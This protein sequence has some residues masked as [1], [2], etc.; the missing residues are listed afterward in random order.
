MAKVLK[1][2]AVVL[3][4]LLVAVCVALCAYNIY[5]LVSCYAFGN[6]MPTVFGYAGAAVGSGSMDD[7]SGGDDI[8]EGDFVIVKSQQDYAVGDVITFYWDG[9]YVTHRVEQVTQEGYI[10]HGDANG[11]YR[12]QPSHGDVVGKVVAVLRGVGGAIE[13]LRSPAGLLV[14]IA[15]GVVVW[16]G[17][18]VVSAL[19]SNN[20]DEK[21]QN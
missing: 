16:I 20:K 9:K 18:D 5:V 14:I 10:T 15:A 12:E 11:D 7:D 3:R 6:G 17:T 19:I 1:I 8:E 2:S 13:F 21:E 4:A